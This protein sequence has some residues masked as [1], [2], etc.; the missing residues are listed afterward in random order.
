MKHQ[1]GAEDKKTQW[2]KTWQIVMVQHKGHVVEVHGFP[3]VQPNQDVAAL[4]AG[5]GGGALGIHVQDRQAAVQLRIVA[6]H[7]L[8]VHGTQAD[9]QLAPNQ[10]GHWQGRLFDRLQDQFHA[11][12][13]SLAV[14]D[15]SHFI[16]SRQTRWTELEQLLARTDGNGLRHF[17]AEQIETLGRDYRQVMSDLAIARRCSRSIAARPSN[18]PA[19]SR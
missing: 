17:D 3:L 2:I 15:D 7:E 6:R 11:L 13:F 5:L 4:D 10:V 1:P 19:C 14:Q 12:F 9:A 18:G 8:G 16:A